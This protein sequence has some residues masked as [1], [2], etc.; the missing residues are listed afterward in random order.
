MFDYGTLDQ[1]TFDQSPLVNSASLLATASIVAI[2]T[3]NLV[4]HETVVP[5]TH[6]YSNIIRLT[7][8]PSLL[9]GS[10]Y[11]SVATLK[12]YAITA[13][14][15]P[16]VYCFAIGSV[17]VAPATIWANTM[18]LN[19][20][21]VARRYARAKQSASSTMR[22]IGLIGYSADHPT[23]AVETYCHAYAYIRIGHP[24]DVTDNVLVIE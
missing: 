11:L 14:Q 16:E 5:D 22:V 1:L 6:F 17:S 23:L 7:Y 19:V 12:K 15:K 8:L 18:T 10:S 24:H 4:A 13:V 2:A 21:G 3:Q 20:I 9:K